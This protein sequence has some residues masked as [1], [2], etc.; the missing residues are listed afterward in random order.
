MFKLDN[1]IEEDSFL[2]KEFNDFQD[3]WILFRMAFLIC[4]WFWWA[5]GPKTIKH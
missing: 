5:W 1:R 2:V 4:W 3:F